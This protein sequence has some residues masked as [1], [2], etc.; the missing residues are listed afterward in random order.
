[1]SLLSKKY[2]S[3]DKD[4]VKLMQTMMKQFHDMHS[5]TGMPDYSS[6]YAGYLP[7]FAIAL[8]ASQESVEK[9]TKILIFLTVV[10]ALL[11]LGDLVLLILFRSV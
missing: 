8:L 11:A 10:L 5:S 6:M 3:F 2:L 1:M 4:D 9:L 7:I